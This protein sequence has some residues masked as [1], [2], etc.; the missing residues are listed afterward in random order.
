MFANYIYELWPIKKWHPAGY[1]IIESVKNKEIDRYVYGMY[2]SE[3]LP[4]INLHSHT[5]RSLELLGNPIARLN[6]APIFAGFTRN[7]V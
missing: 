4:E 3:D 5:F 6:I 7:Q 2:A 1:Q